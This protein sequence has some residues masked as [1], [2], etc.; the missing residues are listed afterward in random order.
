MAGLYA[1]DR[2][3]R[4]LMDVFLHP[5]SAE[6]NQQIRGL[7]QGLLHSLK[8]PVNVPRQTDL[9]ALHAVLDTTFSLNYAQTHPVDLAW[10]GTVVERVQRSFARIEASV[11]GRV[12]PE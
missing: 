7:A 5:S 12:I 6:D 11:F 4:H 3:W 10:A 2:A 1:A 9:D 8:T